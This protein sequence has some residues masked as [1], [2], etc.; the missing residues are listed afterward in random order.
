MQMLN[1]WHTTKDLEQIK[2]VY[3]WAKKPITIKRKYFKKW[4]IYE[5]NTVHKSYK[6]KRF[7]AGSINAKGVDDSGASQNQAFK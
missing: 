2:A 6:Q 1:K 5:F 3:P 7:Q 4:G